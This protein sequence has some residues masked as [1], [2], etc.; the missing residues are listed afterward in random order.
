[1]NDAQ[2]YMYWDPVEEACYVKTQLPRL[3]EDVKNRLV[4]I[5]EDY[6]WSLIDKNS[7]EGKI[8][9]NNPATNLPEAINPPAPSDE[10]KLQSELV[11]LKQYLSDTDYQAIKC[12]ELGL[13]MAT[14]YPESHAQRTAAR[15]RINEIETLL[16]ITPQAIAYPS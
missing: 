5:L 8:I 4:A 14:E 7:T 2:T 3:S 1:M 10:E 12:G 9:R 6:W 11:E 16:G 13:S 15:N